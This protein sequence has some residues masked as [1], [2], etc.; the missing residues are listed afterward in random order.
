[1]KRRVMVMDRPDIVRIDEARLK[2]LR[3]LCHPDRH[4]QSELSKTVS[5]WLAEVSKELDSR[6]KHR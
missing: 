3:Q 2:Q 4:G 5:Q 1:M 6:S